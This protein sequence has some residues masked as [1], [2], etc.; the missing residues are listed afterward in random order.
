[1]I[2]LERGPEPQILAGNKAKWIKALQDAV[3]QYGNYKNI[4]ESEKNKLLS[5]YKEKEIKDSLLKSSHK[6]CAFCECIPGESG[7]PEIDHFKPKSR[8]PFNAF[9][10][11]NLLPVCK[12][13]NTTKHNHDTAAEPIINPYETDPE[14]VFE[15]DCF[16][17][18]AK[19]GTLFEKAHRTIDVCKLNDM[20][21][22]N[23][24]LEIYS[25]LEAFE[26]NLEAAISRQI[27]ADKLQ[28]SFSIIDDFENPEH[29]FSGFCRAFLR[30][31][32][33]YQAA[34]NMIAAGA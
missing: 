2:K 22:K 11:D 6:K 7:Y 34:K 31:S 23:Q 15:Y 20:R 12:I 1:M 9:D 5:H 4:P 19:P 3:T 10:W 26:Q 28:R 21:L 18:K 24:R 27:P 8:Y 17:I 33:T 25:A 32:K 30:N 13:C 29:K 14:T 16:S